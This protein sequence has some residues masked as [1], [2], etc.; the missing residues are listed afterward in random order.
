MIN[1]ES[2]FGSQDTKTL[3]YLRAMIGNNVDFRDILSTTKSSGISQG[4]VIQPCEL[5]VRE[6]S[7]ALK[8][9]LGIKVSVVV[10]FI[11]D[12]GRKRRFCCLLTESG[13]V[14][15][16]VYPNCKKTDQ[17]ENGP[18]IMTQAEAYNFGLRSDKNSKQC[19]SCEW[20]M[21]ASKIVRQLF[22]DNLR[23]LGLITV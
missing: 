12:H 11:L 19:E 16:P 7:L 18:I 17:D 6:S 10:G 15:I 2:K 14:I 4:V 22:E 21:A 9:H 5:A 13:N 20:Y 23:S 8:K 1:T 3:L